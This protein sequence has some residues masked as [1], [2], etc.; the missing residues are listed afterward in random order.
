M[1]IIATQ[2][3]LFGSPK[4]IRAVAYVAKKMKPLEA[5]AKLPFTG[6]SAAL[7]L[8]KVIKTA[9]ANAKNAGISDADLIFKEIQIGQGPSLKRGQPVSRGQ[10][11]SIKKRMSHIRVVL[12]T[13]S[14]KGITGSAVKVQSSKLETKKGEKNGTKN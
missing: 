9:I 10:W 5:I 14:E 11:H 3:F 7:P 4:K 13:T 2:K 6:K 8:I 12:T 1:D